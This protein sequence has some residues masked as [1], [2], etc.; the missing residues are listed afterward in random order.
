MSVSP[1]CYSMNYR[2][3]ENRTH[4]PNNHFDGQA[5]SCWYKK[6]LVFQQIKKLKMLVINYSIVL[7]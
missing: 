2:V 4:I 7:S 3:V 1:R 5:K 6:I